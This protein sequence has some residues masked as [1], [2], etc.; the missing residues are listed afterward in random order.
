VDQAY[1]ELAGS[2]P[3]L[4]FSNGSEAEI[5]TETAPAKVRRHLSVRRAEINVSGSANSYRAAS[6]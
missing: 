4:N 6:R 1:A 3:S 5:Q 2:G